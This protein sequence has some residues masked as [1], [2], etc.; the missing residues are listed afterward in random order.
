MTATAE[1]EEAEGGDED[2]SLN[3]RE[4]LENDGVHDGRLK[5]ELQSL[6][7]KRREPPWKQLLAHLLQRQRLL[8][9]HHIYIRE[10]ESTLQ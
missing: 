1:E 8:D 5:A 10:I 9:S 7:S 2:D 3:D 6:P 4:Y